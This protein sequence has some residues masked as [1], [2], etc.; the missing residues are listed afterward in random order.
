MSA[1]SLDDAG[2]ADAL[3]FEA[4]DN[5]VTA[6]ALRLDQRYVN[7][8]KDQGEEFAA[9]VRARSRELSMNATAGVGA[10]TAAAT[11]AGV[12][13][14]R[15]YTSGTAGGHGGGDATRFV[16]GGGGGGGGGDDS[17][18]RANASGVG[19]GGRPLH[20]WGG[21]S[22]GVDAWGARAASSAGVAAPRPMP[23]RP[24]PTYGARDTE[25][26]D[27][28]AVPSPWIAPRPS[29]RPSAP[30]T[31]RRRGPA[32]PGFGG[33]GVSGGTFYKLVAVVGGNFVSIFDGST[34]YALDVPTDAPG[35]ATR[36]RELGTRLKLREQTGI[37]R[38]TTRTGDGSGVGVTPQR[39]HGLYVYRTAARALQAKFPAR[40]RLLTAPRAL[41]RVEVESQRLWKAPMG[42][43]A[44][45]LCSRLIPREAVL[46]FRRDTGYHP[47]VS[48]IV[49]QTAGRFR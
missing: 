24:P 26:D 45:Y 40:S 15:F 47:S 12:S 33:A 28:D 29:T 46:V 30:S 9:G 11:G 36:T 16:G 31:L 22:R 19:A 43:P 25:P 10:G 5:A 23:P 17:G 21:A 13:P 49:S 32:D 42:G 18:A 48:E 4:D 6:F 44:A 34:Q 14:G 27:G 1:D 8:L 37:L 7:P 41:M 39:G 20:D 2:W 35:I 3:T 38:G